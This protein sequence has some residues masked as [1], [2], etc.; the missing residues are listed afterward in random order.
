MDYKDY[1]KVLGV[2][3][4]A[5]Q[6]LIKKTYRKLAMKYHPDQNKGNKQA[7]EKFKDINEAYEVLGDP[8]KRERYNQLGES[9]SQWQNQSGGRGNFNWND[10]VINQQRGRTSQVDTGG[11]G[12]AF[13]GFSDFFSAIFGG[14]PVGG[15]TQTR[16]STRAQVYEQ[17]VQITLEEAYRGTQ[18]QFQ[19]GDRKIEVKIPAGAV[20]GTKVRVAGAVPSASGAQKSDIHLVIEVMSDPRFTIHGTDLN[21]DVQID[22]FTAILGGTVTIKTLSGEVRLTIPP[23]TQPGQK[24]RLAG[25]G[26][27]KL[28]DN[29]VFGDLFALIKVDIPRKLTEKQ[30]TLFEELK[31]L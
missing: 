15:R 21:A 19:I 1:Y 13:G 5:T 31:N 8:K 25:R 22:L 2:E 17:K 23:G 3:R 24:I 26:L 16:Q 9:Y 27:P 20:T 7:E 29:Q 6:D 12:D 11:F 4:N 18:R 10:W 14:M 30:R 28:K